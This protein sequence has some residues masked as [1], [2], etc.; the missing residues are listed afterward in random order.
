MYAFSCPDEGVITGIQYRAGQ[1]LDFL[2]FTCMSH[3]GRTTMQPYG[4]TGGGDLLRDSCDPGFYISSIH[5]RSS[6]IIDQLGIRCVRPGYTG[7][8]PPRHGHGGDGGAPF[9]DEYYTFQAHRPVQ[10][11]VWAGSQIDAIQIQYANMAINFPL[12]YG[13]NATDN[14]IENTLK[15]D[16]VIETVLIS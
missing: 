9:D 15:I 10:I 5:G 16:L 3:L 1:T 11:R 14:F 4:G 2:Q 8:S 7:N 6:N 12:W 13:L